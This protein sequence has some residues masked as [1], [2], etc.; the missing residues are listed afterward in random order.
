MWLAGVSGVAWCLCLVVTLACQGSWALATLA[1]FIC[2]AVGLL[3]LLLL[4]RLGTGIGALLL[5][6]F[7]R[8]SSSVGIAALVLVQFPSTR[9]LEFLL[10][11][12]VAYLAVL[13]VETRV[14]LL[15]EG[16]RQKSRVVTS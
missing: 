3:G 2:W 9:Q 8:L 15:A 13:V 10:S 4:L 11:L 6:M 16:G 5:A 7:L 14:V 1:V 12:V